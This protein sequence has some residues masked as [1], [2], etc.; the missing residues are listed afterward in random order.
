MIEIDRLALDQ[1]GGRD[2]LI[3]SARIE[4][5][6]AFKQA[7]K[8]ALLDRRWL[9]VERDDVNQKRRRRQAIAGVVE[10][11]IAMRAGRNH[12]GNELA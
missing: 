3:R 9:A 1:R 11:T 12:I 2:Q 4:P 5:E 6:M 7:V 10:L 8:L